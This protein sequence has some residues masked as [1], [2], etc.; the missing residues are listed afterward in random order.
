MMAMQAADIVIFTI[1]EERLHVLLVRRGKEPYRRMHAIPSGFM[2]PGESLEHTARRELKEETGLDVSGIRLRRLR[3]Y[4]DPERDPRG[5]VV[6]TVFLAILPNL[7]EVTGATDAY[8]ADWVEVEESL[9]SDDSGLAFDHGDIL[10]YDLERARH[11]LELT[12]LA[13]DFCEELFTISDLRKVYEAVWGVELNPGNFQRQV[14]GTRG[15]VAVIALA[16]LIVGTLLTVDHRR[17]DRATQW[18]QPGYDTA[19]E[20]LLL[21]NR[22]SLTTAVE[23]V[24]AELRELVDV[25][26][27]L[28]IAEQR[29]PDMPFEMI[30][31]ELD[32]YRANVLPPDYADELA[33]DQSLL[34]PYLALTRMQG[35]K[36]EAAR[37]AITAVQRMIEKRTRK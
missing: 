33:A 31:G 21:L 4:S 14:R 35:V 20:A 27:R 22:L 8:R 28:R 6:S 13:V 34:D 1:R 23:G 15:F 2:R 16:A 30:V 18:L 32:G 24:T 11:L 26:S 7:P 10:R 5:R 9:W 12:T 17:R 3:T 37:A 19:S 25:V 29:S 36:L